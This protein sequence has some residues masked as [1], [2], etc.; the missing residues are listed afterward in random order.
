MARTFQRN[1]EPVGTKAP[2]PVTAPVRAE[3]RLLRRLTERRDAAL[4]LTPELCAFFGREF[5]RQGR[6]VIQGD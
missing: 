6:A 3:D 1:E 5:P 4:H 2:L